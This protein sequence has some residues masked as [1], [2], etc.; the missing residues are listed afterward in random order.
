MKP[1]SSPGLS[2]FSFLPLWSLPQTP[3][4]SE[5]L[6]VLLCLLLIFIIFKPPLDW[7]K[8]DTLFHSSLQLSIIHSCIHIV[9]N[10]FSFSY[11]YSPKLFLLSP[12]LK[13]LASHFSISLKFFFEDP[14]YLF[15]TKLSGFSSDI[16]PLDLLAFSTCSMRARTM[17]YISHIS[18]TLYCGGLFYLRFDLQ[19]QSMNVTLFEMAR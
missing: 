8:K 3:L 11:L 13:S 10:K 6:L 7:K 15:L 5:N 12:H 9:P 4:I 19:L 2:F 14:N 1:V 16:V 17:L 18:L